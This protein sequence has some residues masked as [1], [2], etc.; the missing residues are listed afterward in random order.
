[1]NAS[2]FVLT[3]QPFGAMV[4]DRRSSR[5]L[6]F[7][8]PATAL[9][10]DAVDTPVHVLA[11]KAA[12]D[13]TRHAIRTFF[14][15]MYPRGLFTV[16]GRFAGVVQPPRPNMEALSHRQLVG[17]LAT[18]VE[19][20]SACNLSC[21]HC[22]AGTLPRK[23][24]MSV[25]ELDALFEEL[26]TLGSF[27]LGLTGGEPLARA[28]LLD[29]LDAAT[30]RG[31]HPCLTTNATLLDERMARE[32]GRRSDVWLNVSLD[33]ATAATH[34]A[35]RGAGNFALVVDKLKLLSQYARFTVAFTVMRH[36]HAEVD[37]AAKLARELGAHTA[38]FRP[39]YPVGTA[40]DHLELMPTF[41]EYSGALERLQTGGLQRLHH[42][43]PFSRTPRQ[44]PPEDATSFTQGG[45][46]AANLVAS[47]SAQGDVSPCSFLGPAFECGSLRDHSF[48]HLWRYGSTFGKLR[49]STCG[50]FNG[51][52]RARAQTLA[53][54]HD[55]ADPWQRA[56]EEARQ[57]CV[58][59]PATNLHVMR[60]DQAGP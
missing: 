31:L 43:D 51:G 2:P 53:G 16:D 39:L 4:F 42:L 18:H 46:A 14:E 19:I 27:R 24:R 57:A 20:I 56:F 60:A 32:L 37:A 21:S 54:H 13:E 36:N 50:A 38:V 59:A 23:G 55:A 3:P 5:F 34:D 11:A 15:G 45:C 29:I 28:D 8:L 9:L 33:G 22:F 41:D 30:H 35:V 44:R 17:P 25:A 40:T 1:V 48:E 52:C 26:S 58:V 49:G 12:S 47:V 10:I 6:P 7:D